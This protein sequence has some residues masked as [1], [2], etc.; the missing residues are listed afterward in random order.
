[1]NYFHRKVPPKINLMRTGRYNC[2]DQKLKF[3]LG[4]K[5]LSSV[6]QFKSGFQTHLFGLPFLLIFKHYYYG[7]IIE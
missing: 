2:I 4:D 5:N 1:M 6:E 7:M 3:A